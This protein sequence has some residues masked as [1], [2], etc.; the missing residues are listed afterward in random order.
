MCVHV[1]SAFNARAALPATR[2]LSAD[3]IQPGDESVH[4]CS[5]CLTEEGLQDKD[6]EMVGDEGWERFV[7]IFNLR[8]RFI[9]WTCWQEASAR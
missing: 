4:L 8:G 3:M 9:C 2:R 6:Q 5:I 1:A 7:E